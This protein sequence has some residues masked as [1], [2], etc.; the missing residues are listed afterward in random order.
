MRAKTRL[1]FNECLEIVGGDRAAAA[2]LVLAD[3]LLDRE[4]TLEDVPGSISESLT[5]AEAAQELHLHQETIYRMCRSGQL[6]SFRTGRVIRIPRAG[7]NAIKA[8]GIKVIHQP[9]EPIFDHLA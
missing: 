6:R 9:G 8:N 4:T 2:N 7:I 1:L 5:V 3:A